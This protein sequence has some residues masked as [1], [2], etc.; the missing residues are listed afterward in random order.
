MQYRKYLKMMKS[1]YIFLI[2]ALLSGPAAYAGPRQCEDSVLKKLSVPEVFGPQQQYSWD[3]N[4]KREVPAWY[5]DSS[6]H[7]NNGRFSDLRTEELSGERGPE[8]VSVAKPRFERN[9]WVKF[10][11]WMEERGSIAADPEFARRSAYFITRTRENQVTLDTSTVPSTIGVTWATFDRA[12]IED[13]SSQDILKDHSKVLPEEETFGL[14]VTRYLDSNGH[15]I[16]LEYRTNSKEAKNCPQGVSED[17]LIG[18]ITIGMKLLINYPEFYDK[19]VI[20]A[21]AD[22]EHYRLYRRQFNMDVQTET[23]PWDKPV[24][25]KNEAGEE[26]K[27]WI[28]QTTPRKWEALLFNLKG[29]R[30]I[31]GLNQPHPFRLPD[32][33]EVFAA[34]KKMIAFDSNNH[35][36]N[37]TPN[38]ETE[39]APGIF[40]D[41][42]YEVE[43]IDQKLSSVYISRPYRATLGGLAYE[44]PSGTWLTFDENSRIIKAINAFSLIKIPAAGITAEWIEFEDSG[45]TLKLRVGKTADLGRGVIPMPSTVLSLQ[46]KNGSWKWTR[47]TLGQDVDLDG[48]SCKSGWEFVRFARGS[49]DDSKITVYTSPLRDPERYTRYKIIKD[50]E[51]K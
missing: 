10:Q 13:K 50:N 3:L 29:Y 38:V 2:L 49:T 1:A 18:M 36:T 43:W 23:T 26:L 35:V 9:R 14:T 19:P 46:W 44:F 20:T 31:R 6:R 42:E 15:G 28:I 39:I 34:P 16:V 4:G 24:I 21:Y 51:F 11:N 40:S 47:L 37:A 27:W 25:I 30:V 7:Q 8:V 22:E 48:V 41:P 33:T 5:H 12:D 17:A 32:G 45:S